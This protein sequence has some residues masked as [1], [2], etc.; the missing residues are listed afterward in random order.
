MGGKNERFEVVDKMS[1][2]SKRK[3]QRKYRQKIVRFILDCKKDKC[4]AI[5]GWN[6][7]TPILQFHHLRNKEFAIGRTVF[8]I[9]RMKA[10]MEKCILLCPNCHFELHYEQSK[11]LYKSEHY[12]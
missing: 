10:E 2:E 4:C 12:R 11:R 3:H 1:I 7:F 9:G 6:K 8:E 5:C